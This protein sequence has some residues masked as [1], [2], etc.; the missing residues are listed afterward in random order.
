MSVC[1]PS[2]L[3]R[4]YIQNHQKYNSIIYQNLYFEILKIVKLCNW[5]AI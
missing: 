1:L 3:K 4:Q 5:Y 2:S